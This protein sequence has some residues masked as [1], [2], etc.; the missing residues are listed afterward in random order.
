[1]KIKSKRFRAPNYSMGEKCAQYPQLS[2]AAPESWKF[3]VMAAAYAKEM[4][5][6]AFVRE[7]INEKLAKEGDG[8]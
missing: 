3:V 7:A 8:R 2:I 4:S 5:I 1:M 6:S